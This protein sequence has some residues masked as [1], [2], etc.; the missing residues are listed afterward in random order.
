MS[1]ALPHPS[2]P[3]DPNPSLSVEV[4]MFDSPNSYVPRS[5]KR[6]LPPSSSAAYGSLGPDSGFNWA[7]NL[8]S[9]GKI[10]E[11]T[12]PV[13]ISDSG[14]P[15][16]KVSNAVFERGAKLHNDYIVGIFY[17]KLLPMAKSGVFS[18]I[19]GARISVS[20]SII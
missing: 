18:I 1:E 5:Q 4:E 7:K 20:P 14:R 9:A 12:D 17:G 10:P 15:R 19:C 3:P 13:A 11:S 16:V 6:A 2:I 8:S